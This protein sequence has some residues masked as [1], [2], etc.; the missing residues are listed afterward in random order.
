MKEENYED[1]RNAAKLVYKLNLEKQQRQKR[2][3]ENENKK[4]K[5]FKEKIIDSEINNNES[6]CDMV[7]SQRIDRIKENIVRIQ[8]RTINRSS[9][10]RTSSVAIKCIK[11]N[12]DNKMILNS[13]EIEDE[14]KRVIAL[15]KIKSEHKPIDGK[16][17]VK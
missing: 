8:M 10:L 3:I 4:I 2:L 7:R 15:E 13:R 16:S 5:E 17:L 1:V 11:N 9:A 6:I 12:N 14:I